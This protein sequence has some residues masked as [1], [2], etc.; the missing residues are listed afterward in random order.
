MNV[1]LYLTGVI[2]AL[3]QQAGWD[4]SFNLTRRGFQQS[5]VAMALTLA[6]YYICVLGLTQFDDAPEAGIEG[7]AFMPFVLAAGL[8]A[9]TFVACAYVF[10]LLLNCQDRFR[11]WVIVRH[12]AVFFDAFIAGLAFTLFLIGVL[13][14]SMAQWIALACYLLVLVIDIQLARVIVGVNIIPAVFIGC[15]IHTVSL[16]CLFLA[17]FSI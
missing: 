6:C 10:G 5:F 1:G 2:R 9:L 12:W 16:A 13:P 14:Y 15:I 7:I 3:R 4:A 17:V 8:Y 11:P